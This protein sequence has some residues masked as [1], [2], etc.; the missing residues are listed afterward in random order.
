M[1]RKFKP[2]VSADVSVLGEDYERRP[3]S[4]R[5]GGL[6]RNILLSFFAMTVP[7]LTFSALLIGL[8]YD[9]RIVRN[10]FPSDNLRFNGGQDDSNAIYVG[11]S[12]T[13]LITVASWSSTIAPLL[14]GF[15]LALVSYPVARVLLKAEQDSRPEQL[16]TTFQLARSGTGSRTPLAGE[17]GDNLS[18]LCSSLWSSCFVLG[19]Y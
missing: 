10:P 4:S 5:M 8:I 7:M 1:E 14:I 6:Y 17:E 13:T 16:P 19:R 2:I 11:L 15:A 3:S 12:A 18:R 9:Y